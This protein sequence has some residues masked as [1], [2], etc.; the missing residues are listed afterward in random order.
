MQELLHGQFPS[1]ALFDRQE[2]SSPSGFMQRDQY[3]FRTSLFVKA[4]HGQAE[5]IKTVVT[6][7]TGQTNALDLTG[8]PFS[9][10]VSMG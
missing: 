6:A 3:D 5:L 9:C 8:N 4:F 10:L 1:P 2:I 7:E